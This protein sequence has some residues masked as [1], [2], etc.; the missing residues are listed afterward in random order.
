MTEAPLPKRFE[1]KIESD[2]KNYYNIEMFIDSNSLLN[3]IIKSIDKIP[4]KKY[5]EKF[6][7]EDMKQKNKYFLMS[8]NI[9]DT[10]LLLEPNLKNIDNLKLLENINELTILINIPNPLSPQ[11]EF[12]VK[13]QK[14]DFDSLINEL[15][16]II[17]K[18]NNKIN[19][20]EKTVKNLEEKIQKIEEENKKVLEIKN[21]N[22]KLKTTLSENANI[23]SKDKEKEKIIREWINPNKN[24]TFSLL[25]RMTR[26]GSNI[27]DFHRNCDNK[28]PTLILIETNKNYKFGGYTPINWDTPSNYTEKT[29]EFTFL[30]SLN[31]IK[32][33]TKKD[34]GRSI[35][36]SG[37]YG[38]IFG[39]DDLVLGKNKDMNKGW[40]NNGNFLKNYEL[41]YG[42]MDFECKEVEIFKV[43]FN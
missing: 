13:E 32:K 6:S 41:N 42:E 17:N 43:E 19:S 8:E 34:E 30:F 2:K 40:C 1:Y 20:L 28:G 37:I 22:I 31:K 39:K 15:Y 14:K 35:S 26:D 11:I 7:F 4:E 9:S 27:K 29:D 33:Y 5:H 24:I 12:K 38:P 23:I 36:Q 25:Y 3:I 10:L 18:Q 16:E 21:E